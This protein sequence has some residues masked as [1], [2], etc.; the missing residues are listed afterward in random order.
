M[1]KKSFPIEKKSK[2]IDEATR[3]EVKLEVVLVALANGEPE[4]W[5]PGGER[6]DLPDVSHALPVMDETS[7]ASISDSNVK[8]VAH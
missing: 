2:S 7:N 4:A 3:S 8:E 6:P 1:K 5:S